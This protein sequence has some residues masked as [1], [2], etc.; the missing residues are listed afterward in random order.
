MMCN[1]G[2][3][4]LAEQVHPTSQRFL[5]LLDKLAALHLSKSH[6]YGRTDDPLANIRN[7]AAFVGI[8]PWR[9][10]VVRLSDKVTRIGTYCLKGTL[11]HETVEDSFLDLAAYSLL[12]LLLHQEARDALA[13]PTAVDGRRLCPNGAPSEESR[14]SELLDRHERPTCGRCGSVV[15]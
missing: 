8:E 15:G 14:P 2:R 11:T 6:D 10:C 9:A 3:G 4:V 13:E 7:G 12:T 5:D 1:H